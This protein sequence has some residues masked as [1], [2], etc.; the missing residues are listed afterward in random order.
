MRH[1]NSQK[2]LGRNTSE[3]RKALLRSLATSLFE[4]GK[5]KTTRARA[6]ALS[7]FVD[8]LIS[9]VRRF[10]DF[11]SERESKRTIFTKEVSK[12]VLQFARKTKKNSGFTKSA[13][14]PPREGDRAEMAMIWVEE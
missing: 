8:R 9:R 3:K 14:L 13:I 10:E 5:I 12:R 1:Q 6:K 7:A 11:R 2:K 4:N